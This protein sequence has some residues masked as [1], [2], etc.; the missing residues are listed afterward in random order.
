MPPTAWPD[1][2]TRRSRYQK[3]PGSRPAF[4]VHSLAVDVIAELGLVF[5]LSARVDKL[6]PGTGVS[7]GADGRRDRPE[8][9]GLLRD[10]V[11]PARLG[12]YAAR[13]GPG[14]QG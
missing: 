13:P 1:R 3:A 5:F 12:P 9:A 4:G 8:E 7:V 11:D 10:A 6:A 2:P 14:R